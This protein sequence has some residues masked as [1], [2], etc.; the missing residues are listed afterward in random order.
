M[1]ESGRTSDPR[2]CRHGHSRP[3]LSAALRTFSS[4]G[5]ARLAN[6]LGPA[7][8][9]SARASLHLAHSSER[10]RSD[11]DHAAARHH[12]R[13]QG[14]RAASRR[15]D[16]RA[17]RPVA[18]GGAVSSGHRGAVARRRAPDR[19]SRRSARHGLDRNARQRRAD[20]LRRRRRRAYRAAGPRLPEARSPQAICRRRRTCYAQALGVRVKRLSIRDQSSRWGSCTS[21]G[22]LSFSWR[23]IL[24]PPYVLDYLAAHEVAHLVEMNHSARFWRVVAQGLRPCRARQD[25]ARH[26]R[27]RPASLRHPGLGDGCATAAQA[28]STASDIDAPTRCA[29]A[30]PRRYALLV[31]SRIAYGCCQA[32]RGRW[33]SRICIRVKVLGGAATAVLLF[34]QMAANPARADTMEAALLRAYQ[35]N[36]QL[37]AQRATVRATDENV[38]QALSG[39]RPKVAVTASGGGQYTNQLAD[40]FGRQEDRRGAARPSRRRASR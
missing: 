24:A 2:N 8:P 9:A 7:A 29:G 23:L 14:F 13:R 16:R 15:L 6:L 38:P 27:Q 4:S 21:A 28:A 30:R 5:Q 26:P 11:P 37:N 33:I 12:R 31:S 32:A 3:P 35:N 18:E 39:Y 10:P 25:L 22:S 40:R 36:P 17:S 19:A 20:S 34:I 1:A